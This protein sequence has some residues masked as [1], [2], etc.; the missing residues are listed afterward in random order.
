MTI[1]TGAGQLLRPTAAYRCPPAFAGAQHWALA[2]P[3]AVPPD[4]GA[5]S[6][7][8]SVRAGSGAAAASPLQP[9]SAA[10]CYR[11]LLPAAVA[12][13]PSAAAAAAAAL[14][15]AA[16]LPVAAVLRAAAL[17]PAAAAPPP[18]APLPAPAARHVRQRRHRLPALEQLAAA[19]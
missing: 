14:S 3:R 5:A 16:A 1:K 2:S 11:K 18:A 12:R 6:P 4:A 15:A 7:G 9:T 13:P 19:G 17:L 10:A 8:W